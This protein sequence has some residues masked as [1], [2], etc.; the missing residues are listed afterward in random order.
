[1]LR[2]NSYLKFEERELSVTTEKPSHAHARLSTERRLTLVLLSYERQSFIRRQLLYYSSRSVHIVI[3][4]GSATPWQDGLFGHSGD[5]TWEYL[6][7]P[8]YY[9]YR[10]RFALALER[11]TTEYVCLIEDQEC[12]LWTGLQ[13]A[14]HTLDAEPDRVCAGGLVAIAHAKPNETVLYPWGNRGDPWQLTNPDPLERFR[15]ITGPDTI[16]R[17][18]T[19]KSREQITYVTSLACCKA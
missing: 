4:D 9:T 19:I 7:V 8:G 3:A 14:V 15:K 5:L 13:S 17:I 11:V 2:P 16:L 18:C 1:M 12:I 6:H 10:D